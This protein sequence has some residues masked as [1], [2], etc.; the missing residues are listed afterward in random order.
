MRNASSIILIQGDIP[1]YLVNLYYATGFSDWLPFGRSA[2]QSLF[3]LI[4]SEALQLVVISSRH[5]N[6]QHR[7]VASFNTVVFHHLGNVIIL[8]A[9]FLFLF[10]TQVVPALVDSVYLCWLKFP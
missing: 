6:S 1:H 8:T 3:G 5:V 9:V 4:T 7:P 10:F 2:M